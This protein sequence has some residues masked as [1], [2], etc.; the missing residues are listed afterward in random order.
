[1]LKKEPK[2]LLQTSMSL[3]CESW[4]NTQVNDLLTVG[5]SSNLASFVVGWPKYNLAVGQTSKG[6][7][8]KGKDGD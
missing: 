2:S 6:Q 5:I 3:S 8:K 7:E 4:R 1:M